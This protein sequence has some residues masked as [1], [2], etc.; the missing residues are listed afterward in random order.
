MRSST[1]ATM[2]TS[3]DQITVYLSPEDKEELKEWADEE[4]RSMAFLAAQA[5]KE[6]I[7]KRRQ[8]KKKKS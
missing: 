6:A 8:T 5:I 4:Q 2:P 1:R 7:A 3:K